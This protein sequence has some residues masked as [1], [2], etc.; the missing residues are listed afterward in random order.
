MV[1]EGTLDT[2]LPRHVVG[3]PTISRPLSLPFLSGYRSFNNAPTLRC[4]A[5]AFLT[6]RPRVDGGSRASWNDL[7]SWFFR[8]LEVLVF[9]SW[10]PARMMG[11]TSTLPC[12]TPDFNPMIPITLLQVAAS[13]PFRLLAVA[14]AAGEIRFADLRIPFRALVYR[15]G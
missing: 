6:L 14:P 8:G 1:Y 15:H 5:L 2:S 13:A 10:G 3:A 11:H 12:Q 4:L 9:V 7:I